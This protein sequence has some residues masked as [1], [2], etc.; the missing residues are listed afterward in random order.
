MDSFLTYIEK[1]H[2]GILT[3]IIFHLLLITILLIF[4]L[5][6]NKP[7]QETQVVLDFALPEDVK[8]Q[9]DKTIEEIKKQSTHEFLKDLQQE[10]LGRNIAVNTADN[11]ADKSIDKMVHDIKN[12]MNIKDPTPTSTNQSHAPTD[13]PKNMETAE[14]TKPGYTVNSKGEHVYYK[15]PTTASYYLEGRNDIYFPIPVYKCEGSGK[16]VLDILVDQSGF[17]ISAI[18]N[19]TESKITEDCLMDAAVNSALTSR[20]EPKSNAPGKQ[21]GKISYIFIKQ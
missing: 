18:I 2:V 1:H 5:N 21:K 19:K 17:V 12:E 8:K 13:Q 20:F 9:V 4:Q 11:E 6:T 10:Y 15:G 16:V 14:V 7:K 3:T